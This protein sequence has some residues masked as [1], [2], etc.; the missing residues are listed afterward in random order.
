MTLRSKISYFIGYA[1]G[2]FGGIVAFFVGLYGLVESFERTKETAEKGAGPELQLPE[3]KTHIAPGVVGCKDLFGFDAFVRC[4][5][6]TKAKT[7]N[8]VFDD[9]AAAAANCNTAVRIQTGQS[10]QLVNAWVTLYT[11]NRGI[12][13]VSNFDIAD[14]PDGRFNVFHPGPEVARWEHLDRAMKCFLN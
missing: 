10:V 3:W 11:A 4:Q 6:D 14:L 5:P 12:T 2:S 8:G 9:L 1:I 7:A 13:V